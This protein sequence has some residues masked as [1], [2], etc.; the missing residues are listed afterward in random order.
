MLS[1]KVKSFLKSSWQPGVMAHTFNSS[2]WEAETDEFLSSRS[3]WSIERVP[4]QSG[5]YRETLSRGKKQKNK[6]HQKNKTKTKTK[7]NK[8]VLG[9]GYGALRL[10]KG[11]WPLSG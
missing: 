3:A 7:Q 5:L 2:T 10:T 9:Y 6:K 4:G 8:T 11:L 1:S